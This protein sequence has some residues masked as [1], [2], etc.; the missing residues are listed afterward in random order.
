MAWAGAGPERRPQPALAGLYQSGW[1]RIPPLYGTSMARL[2]VR[3]RR[4]PV[5]VDDQRQRHGV[6]GTSVPRGRGGRDGTVQRCHRP[7][8]RH[9]SSVGGMGGGTLGL[10]HRL[11]PA[12][13]RHRPGFAPDAHGSTCPSEP[14]RSLLRGVSRLVS[15]ETSWITRYCQAT[16]IPAATLEDNQCRQMTASIWIASS[17]GVCCDL[18]PGAGST[19]R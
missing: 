14:C 8:R 5:L 11:R 3:Y 15:R 2:A 18:T 19:P 16:A 10:S 1:S 12:G 7:S 9:G 4:D 6:D 17:T 13:G